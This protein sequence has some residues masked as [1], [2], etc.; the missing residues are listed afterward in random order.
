MTVSSTPYGLSESNLSDMQSSHKETLSNIQD[1]QNMEK[2][3]YSQL[4][5]TTNGTTLSQDDQEQIITRFNELSAM[6][7][8]MFESLKEIYTFQAGNV[9]NTRNDLVN[10]ITTA[11]I[12][13][14]ELNNAKKTLEAL[15]KERYNKL[16]M[17]EINT[18]YGKRY[19][20][21][22]DIMKLVVLFCIPL[23]ILGVLM[24][25]GIVSPGLGGGLI[26]AVL[27]IGIIMV[28]AKIWD[29]M[30]RDNMNFDEYNWFWD[31]RDNDPTVI[32][33]DKEQLGI[34]TSSA[35]SSMDQAKDSMSDALGT[36]VGDS[37]CKAPTTWDSKNQVCVEGFNKLGATGFTNK[38]KDNVN[39]FPSNSNSVM[40][41]SST[42][43]FSSV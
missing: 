4:D 38:N 30:R 12:V 17:V 3:L 25:R 43:N 9:A 13:E 31:P 8:N 10:Q 6:R 11:G 21:Q 20:A 26:S 16:R 40:P 1:L 2:A 22:A 41:Y 27:V 24:N 14:N 23:L 39:V 15:E 28:G 18:Y 37:C 7:T 33:Y 5:T 19:E 35:E 29:Y 36:C 42:V 34:A 32:E